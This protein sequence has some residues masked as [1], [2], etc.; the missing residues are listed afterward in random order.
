MTDRIFKT[1]S[2]AILGL[3]L[4]FLLQLSAC[5]E[6]APLRL[7]SIQREQVDTLYGEIVKETL[8]D[9]MDSI[10]NHMFATRLDRMVD[11]LLN[12][13]RAQENS[14]RQKYRK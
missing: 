5:K 14:L 8:A 12:I 3:F 9:E 10:C 11:S 6:E 2:K 13:R 7:T 1:F 4:L